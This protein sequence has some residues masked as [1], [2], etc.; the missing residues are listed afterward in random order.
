MDLKVAQDA[1]V[2]VQTV[3]QSRSWFESLTEQNCLIVKSIIDPFTLS[4]SKGPVGNCD[5]LLGEEE[6]TNFVVKEN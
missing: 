5:R 2:G 4:L 3:L 6:V 1:W